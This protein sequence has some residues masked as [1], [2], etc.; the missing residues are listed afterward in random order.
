M[1]RTERIE[2]DGAHGDRLA[3]RLEHPVG[4][5]RAVALFAH[6]FTCSKDLKA[7]VRI[8]RRL[9]ENGFA[10][11]RFDF[12]GLGES[13]GDFAETNFSSNLDDLEA[14]AHYL[15]ENHRPPGLLIGHS[16]GGAA[17]LAVAERLDSV[18]AV[19]TIAAP[20][21]PAHLLDGP[22]ADL[23]LDEDDTAEIEIAGR[24]FRVKGQLL[25]D[26][27][28]QRLEERIAAL[29]RSLLLFHSPVDEVVG[30]DHARRIY[31]AAKHPKSFVSLD[32][33]DH[34]LLDD[35]RDGA[36]L[37]EVLAAWASRYVEVEEA[38]ERT[39]KAEEEA[40]ADG[41]VR[42]E[43][44]AEGYRAEVTA[45]SHRWVADE[46]ESV[47]GGDQG[48]NP[49]ELLLAGLGACK[50][51]TMR[52]YADRKEWPLE[53]SSVTLSHGRI[54]AEDCEDCETAEGKI[55]EIR[56][57]IEVDGDLDDEQRHR[58]VEIAERCP[59]HRTLTSE[60]KIR[61]VE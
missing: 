44:G 9:A 50:V 32:R 33:A 45:G 53:G 49:Y 25:R 7:V 1:S 54:H 58:L 60:T 13:A 51:M 16:L 52:M 4:P 23:E 37:A 30:I 61:E 43:G 55:D 14:A 59:V 26:L 11:L 38:E 3:A 22:L 47:G 57:E 56:V 28:E 40:D 42:V 24:P 36:Y 2:F 31:E 34:L 19:A 27:S 8:S 39:E 18:S 12:T 6:C 5:L 21:D 46:P 35:P 29:D 17:V 41:A 48:P 20:S 10:V 15:E